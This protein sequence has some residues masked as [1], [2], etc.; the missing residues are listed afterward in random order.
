MT[1]VV[2]EGVP[3]L[4]AGPT[5]A[6]AGF[7]MGWA[8]SCSSVLLLRLSA[9]GEQGRNASAMQIGDSLGSTLG[10]GGAGALFAARYQGGADAATF[11]L[12]WV[13]LGLLG[14]LAAV[15]AARI[16]PADP[17]RAAAAGVSE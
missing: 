1:V 11:V 17:V 13:T 8:M 5:W 12:I 16:R 3:L 7:G 14:L 15:V 10:I 9:A 4:A 2:G 6:I